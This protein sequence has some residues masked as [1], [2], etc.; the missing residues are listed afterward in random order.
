[1][2]K[3][4][5]IYSAGA[6]H[7]ATTRHYVDAFRQ[8]SRFSVDYLCIE[9]VPSAPLNLS[10]Y[11]AVWVNYC[12][13]ACES[14]YADAVPEGLRVALAAYGGPK[15]VAPQDEYDRTNRL[16]EQL[17]GVGATVVLTCVPQLYLDYVY[18]QG[19]FPDVHFETVLTGY[20][21]D[22]L[23]KVEDVR[24]LAQR[25]I[26]IGYRGRDL[27]ARYGELARQKAE[28]GLRVREACAARGIPSD[29]AIDEAS[30]I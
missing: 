22:E 25:P 6:G 19:M 29:I 16:R 4:L 3:L 5:V 10:G 23:S 2:K 13:I 20:V 14:H 11:D 15:L 18:P 27:G 8:H 17:R 1:M 9:H 30:R 28:I 21:P 26:V 12:A 7:V 24:P